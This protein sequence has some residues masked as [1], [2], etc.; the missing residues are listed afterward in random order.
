MT[1]LRHGVNVALGVQSEYGALRARLGAPHWT[2]TALSTTNLDKVLGLEGEDLVIYQ[3]GGSFNLES[4][5]LGV[6]SGRRAVLDL[7]SVNK[8]FA[9]NFGGILGN[10]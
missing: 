10:C 3:G 1:V 7:Y 9:Y 6:V 5:V 2:Q 8:V 4:T